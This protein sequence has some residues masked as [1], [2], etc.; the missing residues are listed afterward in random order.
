MRRKN[1][2]YRTYRKY[3][4]QEEEHQVLER[5]KMRIELRLAHP[6]KVHIFS[7]EQEQKRL[8]Q[9]MEDIANNESIAVDEDW[10][11]WHNLPRGGPA[12]S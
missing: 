2:N 10:L 8:A 3:R 11:Q 1:K 6:E 9:V 5:E 7:L 12:P 4:T